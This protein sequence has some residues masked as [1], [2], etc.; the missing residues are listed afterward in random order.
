[1]EK[2]P[3][4]VGRWDCRG[5]ANIAAGDREWKRRIRKEVLELGAKILAADIG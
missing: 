3:G 2:W 5:Q 4:S 1:L